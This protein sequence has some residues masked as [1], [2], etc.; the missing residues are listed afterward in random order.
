M[1]PAMAAAAAI[2][3]LARWV[4]APGP[5]RP[6]KLRL[7]VDSPE[8]LVEEVIAALKARFDVTIKEVETAKEAVEFKVPRV[9][10]ER[11]CP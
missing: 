5:W 1:Q 6:T 2:G 11:G 8:L 10:R 7:V 3:G 4:R 9:L